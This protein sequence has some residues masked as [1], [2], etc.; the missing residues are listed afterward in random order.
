MQRTLAQRI[1]FVGGWTGSLVCCV[2]TG[3]AAYN[4]GYIDGSDDQS[5]IVVPRKT[6]ADVVFSI[7]NSFNSR[8]N[9]RQGAVTYGVGN[10]QR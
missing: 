5:P 4:V 2:F 3:L 1:L 8:E 7:A 10:T 6:A 9:K